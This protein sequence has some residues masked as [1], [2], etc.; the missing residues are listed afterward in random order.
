MVKSFYLVCLL[1]AM[2]SGACMMGAGEPGA[3]SITALTCQQIDANAG[4]EIACIPTDDGVLLQAEA[5]QITL[6]TET[7]EITFDATIYWETTD[8]MMQVTVI[9]G[10]AAVRANDRTRVVD[11][12]F[13]VDL[14]LTDN[15]QTVGPPS[16]PGPASTQLLA[17][18]PVENLPGAVEVQTVQD[19][20]PA[21]TNRPQPTAPPTSPAGP[22][23]TQ[24]PAN[25]IQP[26]EVNAGTPTPP[27]TNA[28]PATPC[29]LP[30][31][32][33]VVYAVQRGDTL[34]QIALNN[35]LTV[36]EI[37]AANCIDNPDQLALGQEIRLPVNAE[38]AGATNAPASTPLPDG[39][40]A[41]PVSFTAERD[42]IV[43]GDCVTLT[44][45]TASAQ[46]VNL[47]GASVAVNGSESVC[48]LAT[49]TYEL[50]VTAA[51]GTQASYSITITVTQ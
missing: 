10:T 41:A 11:A 12:G 44:W 33:T 29:Q 38:P 20:A 6:H 24:P 31:D 49:K 40:T 3:D 48:P 28:E 23:S 27:G 15:L 43:S 32:W 34:T 22:A 19:P 18:L 30:P 13:S 2:A 17:G 9:N 35:N 46:V 50:L 42:V 26:V 36:E 7:V 47:D 39:T 14:G 16:N 37:I 51:D 4:T 5:A 45:Q 25:S 8:D 21:A 1:L